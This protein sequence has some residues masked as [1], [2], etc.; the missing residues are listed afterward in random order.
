MSRVLVVDADPFVRRF[1]STALSAFG[2]QAREA[3]TAAE[4]ARILATES[5]F[6]GVIAELEDGGA[7]LV[8]SFQGAVLITCREDVSGAVAPDWILA[9][10]PFGL[11][12]LQ[13]FLAR[14][15]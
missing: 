10:K 14:I 11:E 5:P 1:L 8:R 9:R 3:G 2:V 7:A 15:R 4:A 13:E 12:P 6:Q